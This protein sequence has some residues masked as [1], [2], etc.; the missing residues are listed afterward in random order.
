MQR[1]ANVDTELMQRQ[2]NITILIDFL[3]STDFYAR[4]YSLQLI[5]AVC[6]ARSER[7]QECILAAPLGTTR[8]VGSLEDPCDAIRNGV[9]PFIIYEH[10]VN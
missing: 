8:L 5:Q 4:L 10:S 3:G 1:A 9:A 7:T 6:S 2:D